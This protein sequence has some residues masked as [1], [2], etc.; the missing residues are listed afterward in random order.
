MTTLSY[1]RRVVKAIKMPKQTFYNLPETKRKA[2]MEAAESEFA[3][4]G[5]DL[6]SIQQII[7]TS[8]I[9]RGS[10]YQY[11]EDKE[12]IFG[13]VM[14]EISVRKLDFMR[15]LLDQQEEFGLFDWMREIIK[16]GVE[17][18]LRDPAA[19]K[20]GKDLFASKTLDKSLFIKDMQ[21]RLY[22]RHQ[23]TPE[24]F[25]MQ[26]VQVSQERGE[27]SRDYP[28]EMVM[29]FIQ[30]M[31]DK[32]SEW[33][34]LQISGGETSDRLDQLLDQMLS[35]LQYGISKSNKPG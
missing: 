6:S 26:A 15:P 27:I 4:K 1:D 22:A 17:F 25:F 21:E 5:Y 7:R 2:I 24:M 28:L 29:L 23:L 3:Q 16:W 8:G 19:F 12:D 11:F 35:I 34:W 14:Y 32:L 9:P 20:I 10:F 33:Y 31:M 13:E 18:G 30:G